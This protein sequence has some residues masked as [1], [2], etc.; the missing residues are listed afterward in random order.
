MGYAVG[1]MITVQKTSPASRVLMALFFSVFLLMG[2]AF[3]Y[4]VAIR[5]LQQ[6]LAARQWIQVPCRVL[7]SE[8]KS[9]SDSDGTTYSVEITYAYQVAGSCL[10]YTS[11][12]PRD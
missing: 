10:L 1:I 7:S 6:S 12:S 3:T 2:C 9:H 8:V 4:F 11:P 5:P